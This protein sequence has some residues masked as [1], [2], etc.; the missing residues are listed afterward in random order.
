[1]V[2]IVSAL[3]SRPFCLVDMYSYGLTR[4]HV[5]LS[6]SLNLYMYLSFVLFLLFI[7]CLFLFLFSYLFPFLFLFVYLFLV[8]AAGV[9]VAVFFFFF[10]FFF[11]FCFRG[12]SP[13]YSFQLFRVWFSLNNLNHVKTMSAVFS[14]WPG[15]ISSFLNYRHAGLLWI[16]TT[17]GINWVLRKFEDCPQRRPEEFPGWKVR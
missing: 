4:S 2:K 1:M 11:F 14:S 3:S 10:F 12:E 8:V 9:V 13:G 16:V 5:T 7:F 17:N 6:V 15:A